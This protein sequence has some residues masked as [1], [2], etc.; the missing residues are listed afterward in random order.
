MEQL[1]GLTLEI[2]AEGIVL[3]DSGERREAAADEGMRRG[4]EAHSGSAGQ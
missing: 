4:E 2:R 3:V 1:T